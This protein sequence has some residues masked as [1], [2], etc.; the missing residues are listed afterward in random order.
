[1]ELRDA[2]ELMRTIYQKVD[3]VCFGHK[4]VSGIW[5]NINGI[6]YVLAADNL[7]GKD[8]AREI[9]II[10]KVIAVSDIRIS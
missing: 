10:Q 3:V 5:Q 7:P 2:R 1:M 8:F 4:H 9:N 6:R